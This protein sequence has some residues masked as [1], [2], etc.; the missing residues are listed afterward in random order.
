MTLTQ[1]GNRPRFYAERRKLD[2][3]EGN[4][5]REHV[6]RATRMR[7]GREIIA[8]SGYYDNQQ[9]RKNFGPRMCLD[10]DRVFLRDPT[11]A[12]RCDYTFDDDLAEL[13]LDDFLQ[14]LEICVGYIYRYRPDPLRDINILQSLLADDLSLFRLVDTGEAKMPRFQI[15][16]IDNKHLHAV[17]TDRTFELTQI[18]DLASAQEDYADAWRHYSRGDFDDAATNGG[19]AVESACKAVIKKLDPTSAPENMNLGPLV[20]LLVQKDIIPSAMTSIATHLEHIF[21]ASGGLRNQA[22]NGAHGSVD[23]TTPEASVAL[24]ALR[25]S[26]TLIAFLAERWGQIK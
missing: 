7:I 2:A 3:Q 24:L 10:L 17:I 21:R 22:G 8:A 25:L 11:H 14:A 4:P 6:S 16:R 5:I 1:D 12:F 15:Q 19:K 20:T 9:S 13:S 26:G 23:L 18:A